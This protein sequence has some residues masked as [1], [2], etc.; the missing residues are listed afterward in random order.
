V[1][2]YAPEVVQHLQVVE[3]WNKIKTVE[4][5]EWTARYHSN[6]PMRKAFGGRVEITFMDGRTF[7]DEIAVADA[8]PL[9]ARPF[10]RD[11][12]IRKFQ[13]LTEDLISR[14]ESERFLAAAQRLLE[15]KP[16]QLAE[17]NITLPPGRLTCAVRDQR[18]IF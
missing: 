5:A 11:G 12:Y 17:L 16:A 3:L 9:G 13:M 2:S 14:E 7:T 15:L 4:D 10:A 18:G 8:H 6:D 1:K